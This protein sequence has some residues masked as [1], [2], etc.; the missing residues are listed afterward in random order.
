M[1]G[2]DF[3]VEYRLGRLNTVSDALSRRDIDVAAPVVAALTIS[4]PSFAFLDDVRTATTMADD[5]Q[6]LLRQL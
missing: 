1:F 4:K 2:L 3:I 6:L 5:V